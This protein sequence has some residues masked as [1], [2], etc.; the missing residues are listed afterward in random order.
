MST[1]QQH[2]NLDIDQDLDYQQRAWVAQRVGWAIMALITLAALAGLLGP[3]LLSQTSLGDPSGQ[4]LLEYNRF[5]RLENS[6]QL[7][8]HLRPSAGDAETM[9]IW[10]SRKYS[11][12]MRVQQVTPPPE[13]VEVESDRLVYHFRV[14][15]SELPSTIIF[16][17]NPQQAGVLTGQ[18]GIE[19]GPELSFKQLVYP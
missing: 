3:G 16:Q 11:Q 4:L 19:D 12:E 1:T 2:G 5:E 18:I 17:L 14:T 9:Q 15:P 10:L 6:T 8:V 13:S 7:R